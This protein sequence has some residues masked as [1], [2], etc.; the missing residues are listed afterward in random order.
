MQAAS[1]A[2]SKRLSSASLETCTP[3]T[4]Q[5][6]LAGSGRSTGA[7]AE[8]HMGAEQAGTA[9]LISR[10]PKAKAL[11]SPAKANPLAGCRP[12]RRF[13]SLVTFT[14]LA[15]HRNF[16]LA[17]LASEYIPQALQ[18]KSLLPP[19]CSPKKSL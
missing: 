5:H 2:D 18:N 17:I 10:G 1:Y 19:V 11:A 4:A 12:F 9:V 8:A 3:C 6:E 15:S 14:L 7:E 13:P 16:R